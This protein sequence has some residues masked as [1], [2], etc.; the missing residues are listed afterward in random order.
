[1]LWGNHNRYKV[2]K[3]GHLQRSPLKVS[4]AVSQQETASL[5]F[6]SLKWKSFHLVLITWSVLADSC[7]SGRAARGAIGKRLARATALFPD[8]FLA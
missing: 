5:F 7:P 3:S 1:M 4:H 2:V 8:A 6:F